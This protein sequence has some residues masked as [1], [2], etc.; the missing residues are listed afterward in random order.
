MDEVCYIHLEISRKISNDG[1]LIIVW[2]YCSLENS[3]VVITIHMSNMEDN[4][5]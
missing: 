3:Y 2:I 4:D 5:V 1:I